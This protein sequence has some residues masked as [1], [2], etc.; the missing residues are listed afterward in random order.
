MEFMESRK[1]HLHEL[2]VT[3]ISEHKEQRVV[4]ERGTGQAL[5][6]QQYLHNASS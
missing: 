4:P 2:T 1:Y 3:C 5:I 6:I